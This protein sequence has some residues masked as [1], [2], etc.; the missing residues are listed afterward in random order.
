MKYHFTVTGIGFCV[1]NIANHE[2]L[3]E[4]MTTG[5]TPARQKSA[6]TVQHA[7]KAAL[8][9]KDE[10]PLLMLSNREVAQEILNEYNIE[11]T[12][13]IGDFGRM[14]REALRVLEEERYGNVLL[15]A[16][17][18]EGYAAVLLSKQPQRCMA[19]LSVDNETAPAGG[20]KVPLMDAMMRFI[21]AVVE[22]RYAFQLDGSVKEGTCIWHWAEKR[23]LTRTIDDVT[24]R[25]KE[26]EFVNKAAFEVKR[27][28]LPVTFDTIDQAKENLL[29]IQKDAA[30]QGL[31]QA[32]QKRTEALIAGKRGQNIIVLLAEDYN[33]LKAQTDDL[34]AKSEQLL[35][36]GFQW[37]SAAGSIYIR[38]TT[39]TP[40]VVFMNPPG[41][42]FNSKPFHRYVA[43]LYDFVDGPFQPGRSVFSG[44]SPNETLNRY[45][46][47]VNITFV[48]MYLLE[49]IGIR[50]DYLS[51]ASM[52]EVVFDLSNS[53]IRSSEK[54]QAEDFDRA[55]NSLEATIRY[56]LDGRKE[57]EVAYFGHEVD[58]TKYYLKCNAEEVKQAIAK[59][60]DVFVI[61]EGSPKDVLICGEKVSC[62]KLIQELGGIAMELDDP[63]YVHTPVVEKEFEKIR[64]ELTEAGVY[65]DVDNLPYK[66]FSTYLKKSMDSSTEMFAENFA[67]IITRCV[68]YTEAVRAL[69]DQDARVFI[70]LSTTQLCGN[71]AKNTLSEHP[72]AEVISIYE[73]KDTADYLLDLC[74][75]LL[76]GNVA[77]DFEKMYSKLSFVNDAVED[78]LEKA[79]VSEVK[80]PEKTVTVQQKNEVRSMA[81]ETMPQKNITTSAAADIQPMLQQYIANQM[82]LNQKAYEMYL[83]AEDK[84]FSQIMTAYGGKKPAQVPEA[85]VAAPKKNYLWDRKQAIEM[86]ENSM[87]AVLG[88]KYKEVDQYPIR[89]RMP[90]PPFMFVSRIVSIDAEFGVLRP[91]SIVSEYDLDEDCVFRMGDNQV[92]PLIGAEASHIG[93]FLLAYMGID[94]MYHGTL[95]YRAIGSNQVTYSERPFRVGDTMRTVLRIDRF[96][97]NGS[98]ILIF[99]TFETYNGDELIAV[100]E[101]TGG[102]FTKAE[103]ASN[104]GIISPKK[105]LKKVEPKEFLHFSD[106]VRTSYDKERM[107]AFY[108][109][110]YESCFGKIQKPTLKETYYLPH[111]MKMIDRVTQIDYNGGMYGRGII[112]G[113]KQITPD[114]W[115][116]KA[117]FK[118]DPVFPAIIMTDGVTQLGVFLFAH[119]GL[120]SKFENTTVTAINGNCVASKFRGQARHGYSTLRYEVHVKEVVQTDDSISVY[121]DAKIFNDGLQIIQ[122]ESYALKIVS[123]PN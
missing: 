43:K 60:D 28:L 100:T 6:P 35:T 117:H 76:A 102:F 92:S 68:N 16:Q 15:L 55:M 45:L 93:I 38:R 113:E 12:C 107:T 109:G 22:I 11:Q 101:T 31:Y 74:A 97:Q 122:V 62:G 87:A 63:M 33:S 51:G 103:L 5:K 75:G 88:E 112:C 26:A 25:M 14:L 2:D 94:A 49:A 83:D 17:S 77:F 3:V 13:F 56:V 54:P 30:Q 36:D 66:L 85:T 59:Y 9:Y 29:S 57:Q 111:D 95:S 50:P 42:M 48:V 78:T 58:L 40:K 47:E 10:K 90:L 96:V 64:A 84:L 118:N 41:G 71:W 72:D 119:A 46:Q 104:K 8:K 115:P 108:S 1:G 105:L 39:Q 21:T 19:Q 82:V 24:V 86:T 81:K 106:T 73:E 110:N 89:A 121:F 120:L 7:V 79:A 123:D 32:M 67:A 114:M 80:A 69:Y 4:A 37:K 27:Y 20:T 52:G 99:F 18:E 116:F 91:S 23:E 98:T 53:A 44:G 61:I 70:D 34:L 65:L